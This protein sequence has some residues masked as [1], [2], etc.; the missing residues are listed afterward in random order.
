MSAVERMR[1]ELGK[2]AG[3]WMRGPEI[4]ARSVANAALDFA[5]AV[6]KAKREETDWKGLYFAIDAAQRAFTAELERALPGGGE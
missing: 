3:G 2:G 5:D 6:E 1:A 4:T